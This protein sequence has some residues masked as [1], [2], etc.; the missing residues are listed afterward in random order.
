[1]SFKELKMEIHLP[2]KKICH[3][4]RRPMRL[5]DLQIKHVSGD[6]AKI[7]CIGSQN[8]ILWGDL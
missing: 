6:D 3:F 4:D 1:M 2:A 8:A 5:P 7:F